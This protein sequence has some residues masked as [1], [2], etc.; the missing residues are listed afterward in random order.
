MDSFAFWPSTNN[1]IT[2]LNY[3]SNVI[4]ECLENVTC[5]SWNIRPNYV[6]KESVLY[7][8]CLDIIKVK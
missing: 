7:N 4:K 1:K 8:V 2:T 3:L 5:W 6:Q